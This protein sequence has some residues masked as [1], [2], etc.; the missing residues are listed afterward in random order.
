[1]QLKVNKIINL[2]DY[3][4]N[5]WKLCRFD[6]QN[7][8]ND[9]NRINILENPN[10]LHISFPSWFKNHYGQ[11]CQ[12]E[13]LDSKLNLKFQ[14]INEGNLRICLR[15]I[16]FRNLDNI[17]SPI[18]INFTTFKIN[19]ELIFEEDKLIWHD[20]PYEFEIY[21]KDKNIYEI[22]FIATYVNIITAI[23]IPTILITFKIVPITFFVVLVTPFSVSVVI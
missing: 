22:Y 23:P 7:K 18:Y 21:S 5:C 1:M 8:G 2:I 17:R 10:N 6:L 9:F 14:C 3:Q 19:N 13:G 12:I 4:K 11:G 15:G 20:Q 16:D